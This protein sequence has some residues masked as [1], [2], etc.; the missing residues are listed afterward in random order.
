MVEL[1]RGRPGGRF[2]V[3]PTYDLVIVFGEA[4]REGDGGGNGGG[5]VPLL[6][7]RLTEPFRMRED[8]P[9]V[10]AAE[11][12]D[13]SILSAGEPY[14]GP[15]D[16]KLGTFK[17]R[18][19]RGGVIERKHGAVVQ[20]AVT[21]SDGDPLADNARRL[22]TAW[23]SLQTSGLTL[24]VNRLGHAWYRE[25]GEPRFLAATPGGFLWPELTEVQSM[26]MQSTDAHTPAASAT[27]DTEVTSSE[28]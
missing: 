9:E 17:L 12:V 26:E 25:G 13:V 28:L 22:L 6:V 2:R 19:K 24:H 15:T 21:E 8:A 3:T 11:D 5:M 4:R 1:V 7:G 14:P 20:F 27:E 16:R 18:Q 10:A 23:Q